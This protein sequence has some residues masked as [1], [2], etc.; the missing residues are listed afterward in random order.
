MKN[1][2]LISIFMVAVLT[3]VGWN[4]SES[5]SDLALSDVVLANIEA[6]ANERAEPGTLYGNADG[7]RFCCCPGT[8]SC[9]AAS[10][11]GC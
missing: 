10:C 4:I 11:S 2:L 9:A 5:Q 6:L 3:I 1:K 7:T 8:N